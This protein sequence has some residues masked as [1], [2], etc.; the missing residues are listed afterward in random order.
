M[1]TIRSGHPLLPR[2]PFDSSQ[3]CRLRARSPCTP[4]T[5]ATS[6]TLCRNYSSN[7]PWAF[8]TCVRM[9]NRMHVLPAKREFT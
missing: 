3:L 5:L 6:R 1:R 8:V 7:R 9:Y 4:D 2:R